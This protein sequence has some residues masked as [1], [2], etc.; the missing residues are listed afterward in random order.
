MR[1]IALEVDGPGGTPIAPELAA[2]YH[3]AL[4]VNARS[5]SDVASWTYEQVV[6]RE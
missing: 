1:P 3:P 5:V 2:G 6:V 4:G